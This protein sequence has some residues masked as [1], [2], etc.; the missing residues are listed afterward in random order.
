MDAVK[1]R[2]GAL[3]A[4]P[5]RDEHNIPY[6]THDYLVKLCESQGQYR[7]PH[8]NDRL[9]LAGKGFRQIQALDAY[10][11]IKALY[12]NDNIIKKI[13][14]IGH[15]KLIRSLFLQNNQINRV[16]GLE[17]LTALETLNLSHNNIETI[18]N[19]ECLP[20]L[21]NLDLSFNKITENSGI[22]RLV[23]NP[24]LSTV[25]F[26]NNY[27]ASDEDRLIEY[28]KQMSSL[29]VL[30]LKQNPIVG[31]V[32]NYRKR[33][34]FELSGLT[35]I[36]DKPVGMHER[37]LA[38]SFILKGS[39]GEAAERE[40]IRLEGLAS[41]RSY[42][43]E[44]EQSRERGRQKRIQNMRKTKQEIED[45]IVTNEA[46]KNKLKDDIYK[47]EQHL[48]ERM[49]TGELTMEEHEQLSTA[50]AQKK[51]NLDIINRNIEID[52][53]QIRCIEF[54]IEQSNDPNVYNPGFNPH[55]NQAAPGNNNQ[56]NQ[57]AQAISITDLSTE[58]ENN[59][60]TDNQ[61][62]ATNSELAGQRLDDTQSVKT[63][64][65]T[66]RESHEETDQSINEKAVEKPTEI[67]S[68]VKREI[69]KVLEDSVFN[70]QEAADKLKEAFPMYFGE[71]FG[72]NELG[73]M[74]AKVESQNDKS[75]SIAQLE[76]LD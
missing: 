22:D 9:Y 61:S 44:I 56:A 8:L 37:R 23:E 29:R 7:T 66:P 53:E 45:A 25:N 28:F 58:P 5:E 32:K 24:K 16:E 73:K 18:E 47:D 70:F 4:D 43:N 21:S 27:I 75:S 20:L 57:N 74:W 13:E 30:Y 65:E 3:T 46:R 40:A 19:L 42:L 50:I 64:S 54:G 34:L 48:Y 59:S 71:E 36:D 10:A 33:M 2:K 6:I 63:T 31:K 39:E 14:N 72:A 60:R 76:D 17:G 1:L 55:A 51:V 52:R 35:Y 62:V 68:V 69:E 49:T 12:L 38:T 15:L 41:H 11:N 67:S 26:T